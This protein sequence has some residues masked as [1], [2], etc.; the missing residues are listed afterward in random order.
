VVSVTDPYGRILGLLD[1]SRYFSITVA[2]QLYSRGWVDPVPNPLLFFGVPGNRTRDPCICSQELWPLEHRGGRIQYITLF[3]NIL[4][5]S[6]LLQRIRCF[7]YV[8]FCT[9]GKQESSYI[10]LFI[11]I[12]CNSKIWTPESFSC[13]CCY[14]IWEILTYTSRNRTHPIGIK[15][16]AK[17]LFR[18]ATTRVWRKPSV[19]YPDSNL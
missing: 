3:I 10:G 6:S 15:C 17:Y 16:K 18:A 14:I 19:F 8:S 12:L 4:E 11:N 9:E 2:P 13:D 7:K 5:K 1:R